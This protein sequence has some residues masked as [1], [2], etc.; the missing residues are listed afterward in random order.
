VW[1]SGGCEEAIASVTH[2]GAEGII[3]LAG[4]QRDMSRELCLHAGGWSAF[5]C[6]SC[7]RACARHL[8]KQNL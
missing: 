6:T 3:A 7:T 1:L 4:W 5:A 8:Q 2:P